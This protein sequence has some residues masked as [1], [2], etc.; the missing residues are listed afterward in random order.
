[1]NLNYGKITY[2]A[3]K[4]FKKKKQKKKGPRESYGYATS[5]TFKKKTS[6]AQRTM[7]ARPRAALTGGG[8]R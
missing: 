5:K 7:A 3:M 8:H 4:D 2:K 1:L 6:R